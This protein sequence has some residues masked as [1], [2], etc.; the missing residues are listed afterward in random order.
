MNSYAIRAE[1][2]PLSR[3]NQATAP[4]LM[5]AHEL[6]AAFSKVDFGLTKWLVV[7]RHGGAQPYAVYQ[8]GQA[9]TEASQ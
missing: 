8:G 5:D 9:L 6:A 7:D 1:T 4:T 3:F 2:G